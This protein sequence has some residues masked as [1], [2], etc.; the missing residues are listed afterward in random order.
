MRTDPDGSLAESVLGG[1][2]ADGAGSA[3]LE[4]QYQQL[5][6]GQGGLESIFESPYGVSLPSAPPV[7]LHRPVPGTGLEL[8]IDAPL[9]FVTEQALG[10]E[11]VDAARRLAAPRSSWTRR[12][13]RSSRCR[14]S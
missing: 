6:A 4:Y 3:G 2:Y 12:P 13:A 10:T 11:L 8:T 9:Q 14:A 5:L 7:I 1:T